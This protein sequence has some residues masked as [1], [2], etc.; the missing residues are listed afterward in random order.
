MCG[1]DDKVDRAIL[2]FFWR[3]MRERVA[4]ALYDSVLDAVK[5]SEKSGVTTLSR[6]DV[7]KILKRY[8]DSRRAFSA[9]QA[10][11]K[12]DLH[13]TG[14]VSPMD[15]Q[16]TLQR[17]GMTLDAESSLHLFS[18]LSMRKSGQPGEDL[19]T[20]QNLTRLFRDPR[21][22]L[23]IGSNEGEASR[24]RSDSASRPEPRRSSTPGGGSSPR[25]TLDSAQAGSQSSS[26]L[27]G[28]GMAGSRRLGTKPGGR[29]PSSPARPD[30][31]G[32]AG[33]ASRSS[34]SGGSPKP[35]STRSNV[36]R[37]SSGRAPLGNSHSGPGT[38]RASTPTSS[39]GTLECARP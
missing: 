5:T 6:T 36:R 22:Q 23:E 24:Q 16:Q 18:L 17:L 26:Q 33:N 35:S 20:E 32:T 30:R 27:L 12:L 7:R 9:T 1:L 4:S 13:G 31:V 29:T 15:F 39:R 37:P 14:R 8:E 2:Q 11:K 10:F 28:S 25:P 21:L 34:G 19:L 38:P 3:L